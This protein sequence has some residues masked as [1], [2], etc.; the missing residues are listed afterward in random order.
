MA[1]RRILTPQRIVDTAIELLD[2]EGYREFSMRKLAAVIGVDPM[3]IYHH[4]ANRADLMYRVVDSVI[5]QC[6]LPVEHTSWEESVKAICTEFR[7]LAHRHPGVIQIFDEFESWVPNEH[8]ITEAM[9]GA[10][11][12]GG[13]SSQATVRGARLLLAYTENFCAWELS[14]WIAPYT[15]IMRKEFIDSLTHGEFPLALQLV[16]EITHVVPDEEFEFGLEVVVRGLATHP[17]AS[18]DRCP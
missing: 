17:H 18:T 15:P 12:R 4:I 9:Y 6:E 11:R 5:G 14:D 1:K 2:R 3:A 13:F 10:L 8:R 16:D 7:R